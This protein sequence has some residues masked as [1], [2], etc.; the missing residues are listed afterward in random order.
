MK[1][2]IQ[3]WDARVSYGSA[4]EENGKGLCTLTTLNALE[5]QGLVKQDLST[6]YCEATR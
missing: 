3:G 1:W 5:R 2:L 4:I 6:R